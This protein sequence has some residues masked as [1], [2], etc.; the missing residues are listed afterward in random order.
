MNSNL[1]KALPL[2]CLFALAGCEQE[3]PMERAGEQ[4]DEAA[5]NVGENFE[6]HTEH[7]GEES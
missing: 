3:G 6:E 2:V 4:V 7:L 5:E 1:L